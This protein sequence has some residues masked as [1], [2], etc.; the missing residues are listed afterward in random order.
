MQVPAGDQFLDQQAGHDG[1]AGAGVVGQQKAQRLA[2]QHGLVDRGDLVRQGIDDGGVH[3]QDRVEQVGQPNAMG[4]RHQAEKG[5]VAV[6]AP[7]SALFH[8]LQAGLVVAV[9][10]FIGDL[11][12]RGLVGQLQG[13]GAEPLDTDHRYQGIGEDAA[14]GGV[15]LELFKLHGWWVRP[16]ASRGRKSRMIHCPARGKLSRS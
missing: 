12:R 1:L 15:G 8:Q 11:T 14:D 6:E 10:Q 7:G 5:A 4:L 9:K 16:C 2:R 13:L 3:R